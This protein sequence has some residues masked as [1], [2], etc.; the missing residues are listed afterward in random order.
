MTSTQPSTSHSYCSVPQCSTYY[1]SKI[2]ISFHRFP[3]DENMRKV[4]QGVLQIGK[5][6]SNYMTVCSLHFTEKDYFPITPETKLKRLKKNAVPSAKLPQRSH[7]VI[8]RKHKAPTERIDTELNNPLIE[9]SCSVPGCNNKST[10]SECTEFFPLP[11]NETTRQAWLKLCWLTAEN[12]DR[13]KVAICSNHFDDNAYLTEIND[14]GALIY[15]V[16][17]LDPDALPTLNLPTA[18]ILQL[19]PIIEIISIEYSK[20]QQEKEKNETIKNLQLWQESNDAIQKKID[21]VEADIQQKKKQL[22]EHDNTLVKLRSQDSEG[23]SDKT[24]SN[25]FSKAQLK[26]LFGNTRAVWSDN[27]FAVGYSIM[28]LSNARFYKYLT[29]VLNYPFPG[30][31]TIQSFVKT[32]NRMLKR[33]I[34]VKEEL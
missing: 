6:I 7:E 28:Q 19:P 20:P 25:V 5:P 13:S 29:K 15:I 4:W 31:S 26:L 9:T 1:N 10:G 33:Q 30:R 24:L 2:P 32:K 14:V 18:A 3:L 12:L 21:L 23:L 16:K 8:S 34:V 17:I 27:D 22:K 11:E